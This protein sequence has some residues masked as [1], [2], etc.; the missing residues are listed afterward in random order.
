MK[1]GVSFVLD[2][3]CQ[4]AFENIKEYFI[5]PLVLLAPISRKPF[6]LYVRAMDHSLGVLLAQKNDEGCEQAIYYL[7]RILI[8]AESQYNPI[9]R[10][11]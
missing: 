7:R 5:K 3:A 4:D 1:K 11:V 2:E 8:G 6:L 9:R 10:S